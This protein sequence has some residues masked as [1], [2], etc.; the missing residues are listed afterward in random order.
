MNL[1]YKSGKLYPNHTYKIIGMNNKTFTLFDELDNVEHKVSVNMIVKHFTLPYVNTVHS[2]QGSKIS[3]RYVVCDY[4]NG[5]LT[6]KWFYTAITR[7]TKLE[8][9]YFLDVYLGGL[10]IKNQMVKMVANYKY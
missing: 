8:D 6:K 5:L 3:S 10:N 2:S 9:I 1:T 4:H 7:C